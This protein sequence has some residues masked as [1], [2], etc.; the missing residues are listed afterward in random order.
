MV[1]V[2]DLAEEVCQKLDIRKPLDGGGDLDKI[3]LEGWILQHD[4][5]KTGLAAATVWTRAML[6]LEP[7][8][9]SALF[10]LNY[11]SS[12]GGLM[13]MRGDRRN[14]GQYLR[15]VNGDS[16]LPL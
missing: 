4:G 2:R 12:G 5:G 11:C 16:M 3:T 13:Q 7:R 6:G 14:G 10:F 8:E 1:K 9:T 15:F